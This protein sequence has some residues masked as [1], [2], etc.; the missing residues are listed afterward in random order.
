MNIMIVDDERIARDGMAGLIGNIYTDATIYT[1]E[2]SDKAIEAAM[3]MHFD[4]AFCDIMME[5]LS[6]IETAKVLTRIDSKINIIFTTG[7]SNF[8]KEAME[9]HVSGYI[10][11]PVT[12]SKIIHELEFL[13]Y[14]IEKKDESKQLKAHCFGNFDFFVGGKSLSFAYSKTRELLAYL[15]DRQGAVCS[16]NEIASILGEE[17]GEELSYS[18]LN[19]IRRDLVKSFSDAGYPDIVV[20]SRGGLCL[21]VSGIECDYY[22]LLKGKESAIAAYNGEYMNQY[23]W[24]EITNGQLW[25]KYGE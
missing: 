11:K 20:R 24:A 4:I 21:D 3:Q 10:V 7:F 17:D 6:G 22:D 25:K 23:S 2:R 8:T 12:K 9:L 5:P 15:I 18:Y 1:Y 13:R 14:P 16:N 19:G